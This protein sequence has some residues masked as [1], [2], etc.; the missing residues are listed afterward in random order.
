MGIEGLV[1]EKPVTQEEPV[2]YGS[3]ETLDKFREVLLD[4]QGSDTRMANSLIRRLH[5]AGIHLTD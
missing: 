2:V 1:P 5:D 3:K 4:F